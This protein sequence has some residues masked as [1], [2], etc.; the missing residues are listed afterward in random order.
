MCWCAQLMIQC[1]TRL[2]SV[3][4]RFQIKST[5]HNSLFTNGVFFKFLK[6]KQQPEKTLKARTRHLEKRSKWI[7]QKTV[8]PTYWLTHPPPPLVQLP[9]SKLVSPWSGE[10]GSHQELGESLFLEQDL[11]LGMVMVV[12]ITTK[13]KSSLCLRDQTA[14]DNTINAQS[15]QGVY[16]VSPYNLNSGA[17]FKIWGFF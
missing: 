10:I 11:Y 17:Q 3:L 2:A 9:P 7:L 6:T 14:A 12:E 5:L 4:W 8:S 15:I 13:D 1:E 16:L